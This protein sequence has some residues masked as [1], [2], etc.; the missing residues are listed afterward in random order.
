MPT[1]TFRGE[2]KKLV[3]LVDVYM[4]RIGRRDM[5]SGSVF[6]PFIQMIRR[7]KF[8]SKVLQFLLFH[9]VYPSVEEELHFRFGTTMAKFG[10]REFFMFSGLRFGP[11]LAMSDTPY[12]RCF[13]DGTYASVHFRSNALITIPMIEEWLRAEDEDH[14]VLYRVGLVYLIYGVMIGHD[15][16]SGVPRDIFY[17]VE[18]T[19][20]VADYPWGSYLWNTTFR[21]LCRLINLYKDTPGGRPTVSGVIHPLQFWSY[22][23]VSWIGS[24]AG[25]ATLTAP[26]AVPR[27]LCWECRLGSVHWSALMQ[28]AVTVMI[29]I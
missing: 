11:L 17:L 15:E 13:A 9:T 4:H 6:G 22:E 12:S 18:D 26:D 25:G 19:A 16:S 2:V 3:D 8:S 7:F 27:M 1:W 28:H 20:A 14:E 10:R 23:T 5:I 29:L 21:R 24:P